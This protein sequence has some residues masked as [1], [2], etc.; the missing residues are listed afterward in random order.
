MKYQRRIKFLETYVKWWKF[1]NGI[2]S[3]NLALFDTGEGSSKSSKYLINND[4]KTDDNFTY[5]E[6][7]TVLNTE[8]FEKLAYS[9]TNIQWAS[10]FVQYFAILYWLYLIY[11]NCKPCMP[12]ILKSLIYFS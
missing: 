3:N 10:I 7:F 8:H 4:K 9:V 12:Y 5:I 2:I 6:W 1:K 11:S